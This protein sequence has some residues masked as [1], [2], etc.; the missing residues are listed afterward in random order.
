MKMEALPNCRRADIENWP[1]AL[2]KLSV[3]NKYKK[4]LEKMDQQRFEPIAAKN[5]DKSVEKAAKLA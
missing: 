5:V 3:K 1:K 4:I 2:K